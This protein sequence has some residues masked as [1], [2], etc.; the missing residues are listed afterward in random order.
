MSTNFRREL[1]DIVLFDAK[2]TT[3]QSSV[4]LDVSDFRNVVLS[5]ATTGSADLTLKIQGGL[6]LSDGRG[7]YIPPTFSSSASPSN[8]WDYLQSVN[9][10]NGDD[11]DG[12]TGIVYTGTD[13]VELLEVNTNVIDYIT[14]V[15]TAHSAGSVT[16]RL[17]STTN[18]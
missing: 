17:A 10:N 3:G 6:A 16:V 9:L 4:V 15:V 14:V 5:V 2:A 18:L 8:P 12:D 13:S 11:I 7:Q 1:K